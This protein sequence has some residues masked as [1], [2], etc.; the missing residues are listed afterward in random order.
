MAGGKQNLK[1]A[2]AR[3]PLDPMRVGC[4]GNSPYYSLVQGIGLGGLELV[5]MKERG[6]RCTATAMSQ[7]AASAEVTRPR[8][9]KAWQHEDTIARARARVTLFNA[10]VEPLG[11]ACAAMCTRQR[12]LATRQ[13]TPQR[14]EQSWVGGL[15]GGGRALQ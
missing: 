11:G 13:V 12:D 10:R 15:S 14:R 4:L 3:P 2:M 1:L 7:G 5:I 6:E 9:D 8:P